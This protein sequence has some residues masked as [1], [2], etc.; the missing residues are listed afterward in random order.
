MN[1]EQSKGE[2]E[3]QPDRHT[4][5]Q[6]AKERDR[7]RWKEIFPIL[8]HLL[9]FSLNFYDFISFLFF[10]IFCFCL[11]CQIR[12]VIIFLMHS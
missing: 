6:T 1:D 11:L 7:R 8:I 12:F 4:D 3:R 2:S 9:I 5:R 10:E